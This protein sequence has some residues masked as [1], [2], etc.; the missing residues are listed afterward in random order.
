LVSNQTNL[1]LENNVLKASQEKYLT[2]REAKASLDKELASTR[3][4]CEDLEREKRAIGQENVSLKE[5]NENQRKQLEHF[6]RKSRDLE[7]KVESLTHHLPQDSLADELISHSTSNAP[8]LS[9][10]DSSSV[11]LEHCSEL[12]LLS[13]AF[14]HLGVH[15]QLLKVPHSLQT[16][17]D[18][19][20]LLSPA[21][22]ASSSSRRTSSTF[23]SRL[24][25]RRD[26]FG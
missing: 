15:V 6:T 4:K 16:E 7:E 18:D 5:E 12:E 2:E 3:R 10:S 17:V 13:S 14:Y 8:S 22:S 1:F 26:V 21:P 9:P 23:L 20:L 11:S 19:S 24:R 25:H